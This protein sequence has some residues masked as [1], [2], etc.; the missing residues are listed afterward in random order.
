MKKKHKDNLVSFGNFLLSQER[1]TRFNTAYLEDVLIGLQ[2]IPVEEALSRVTDADLANW[3][4]SKAL[5]DKPDIK[6]ALNHAVSAIYFNDNSD[7]IHGLYGVIRSLTGLEEPSEKDIK[8]L[9]KKLN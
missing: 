9:Y 5:E 7:Y 3:E 2:P 6:E 1:K 4:T 8:K